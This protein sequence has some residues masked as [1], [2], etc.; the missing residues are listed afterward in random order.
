VSRADTL[1][2]VK[3]AE[4]KAMEIVQEAE[5]KQKTIIASARRE[6]VRRIQEA[7]AIMEA[8]FKAAVAREEENVAAQRR[9][10]L[11]KASEDATRL[12]ASALKNM[13]RAKV[14]VVEG[15]ERAVNAAP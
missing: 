8:E 5:E 1:L 14:G 7:E 13:D 2:K 6:A 12:R 10:L 11:G 15:F 3:D 9:E 4:A